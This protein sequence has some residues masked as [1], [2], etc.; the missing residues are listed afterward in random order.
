M[1][2]IDNCNFKE[3]IDINAVMI[4]IG[5]SMLVQCKINLYNI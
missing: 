3:I 5:I 2:A 4:K 1:N